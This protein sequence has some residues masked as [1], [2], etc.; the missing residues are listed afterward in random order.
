MLG[1]RRE[2]IGKK[3]T[4]QGKE[5][6]NWPWRGSQA[7]AGWVLSIEKEAKLTGGIRRKPRIFSDR[8]FFRLSFVDQPQRDS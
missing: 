6:G 7:T 8:L 1:K 4:D 3:D 2:G 5:K